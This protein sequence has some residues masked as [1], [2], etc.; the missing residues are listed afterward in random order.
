[1]TA[2]NFSIDFFLMYFF[3]FNFK[4]SLWLSYNKN[5]YVNDPRGYNYL[6]HAMASEYL[7]LV[8]DDPRIKLNA[9]VTHAHAHPQEMLFCEYL[10]FLGPKKSW[11]LFFFLV[12]E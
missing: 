11:N 9:K 6:V 3:F 1:M 5:S 7:D 8:H 4:I 10:F 12:Q 2:C